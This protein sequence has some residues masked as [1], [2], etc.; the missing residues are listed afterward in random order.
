[1]KKKPKRRRKIKGVLLRSTNIWKDLGIKKPQTYY[2]GYFKGRPHCELAGGGKRAVVLYYNR[3][4][5]EAQ[6]YKSVKEVA[7]RR[8][9]K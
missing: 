8:L 6:C 9:E 2:C 3:K 1:M 5:A 4:D 7:I